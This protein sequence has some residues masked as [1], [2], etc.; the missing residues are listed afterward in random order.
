MRFRII[1]KGDKGKAV[2]KANNLLLLGS[3]EE[4]DGVTEQAVKAIQTAYYLPVTGNI[5]KHTMYAMSSEYREYQALNRL[6][7]VNNQDILVFSDTFKKNIVDNLIKPLPYELNFFVAIDK[8][9][10]YKKELNVTN[11]ELILLLA[12]SRYGSGVHTFPELN[13]DYSAAQLAD[14][15]KFTEKEIKEFGRWQVQTSHK[16]AICT[17]LE[18]T[19]N[20][21]SR[22]FFT[23]LSGKE[24]YLGLSRFANEALPSVFEEDVLIKTPQ[25]LAYTEFALI[26]EY[27]KLKNGIP[28]F[29]E[30]SVKPLIDIVK[31]IPMLSPD[32]FMMYYNCFKILDIR[33]L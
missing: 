12:L 11:P 16:A 2:A 1:K 18:G 25:K 6:L 10:E 33:I 22:G 17:K 7:D 15:G 27:I 14:L 24:A 5:N 4:F 20:F 3:K 21:R 23:K 8:L 26:F 9:L 28:N 29:T 19:Y 31:A 13:Y 30:L 32:K